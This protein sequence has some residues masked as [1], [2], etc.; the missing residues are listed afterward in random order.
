MLA[1]ASLLGCDRGPC[2]S[3]RLAMLGPD[4]GLVSCLRAEDCPLTGT[5]LYCV[6]TGEPNYLNQACVRCV[7][8]ACVK[9]VCVP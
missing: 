6:D 7:Q 9:D 3:T 2:N 4:G 5:L 1:G 8:T